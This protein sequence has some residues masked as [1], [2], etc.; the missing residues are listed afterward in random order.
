MDH[1][2]HREG[3][4]RFW[5]IHDKYPS[6]RWYNQVFEEL[7]AREQP[8]DMVFVDGGDFLL[9]QGKQEKEEKILPYYLDITPVTNAQ[10]LEFVEAT[11]YPSPKHWHKN[12]Y[13]IGKGNHPVTWISLEDAANYASWRGKR[14]PLEAEWEK[15]ARGNQDFLWPWGGEFQTR[16]SNCRDANIGDTTPVKKFANGKS[17]YNCYDMSGNVWEWVNSWFDETRT[18]KVLRGGSWYTFADFTT[19]TYR[20][21]DYPTSASGLYGFRCAKNFERKS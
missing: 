8:E 1:G 16:Y 5:E 18:H 21:F 15:A 9:R 11:N 10:Y 4:L 17:V 14:L 13:P 19:T 7:V 2:K 12:I 3:L 20:Y 6:T